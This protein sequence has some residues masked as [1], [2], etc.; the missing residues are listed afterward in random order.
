[1]AKTA[2]VAWSA[3]GWEAMAL[4]MELTDME[5]RLMASVGMGLESAIDWPGVRCAVLCLSAAIGHESA[6]VYSFA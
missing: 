4:L 3:V 5:H 1:M 2:W 6:Y